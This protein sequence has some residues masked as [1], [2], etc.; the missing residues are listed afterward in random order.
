MRSGGGDQLVEFIEN[1]HEPFPSAEN[2][3]H[4]RPPAK[5]GER[6]ADENIGV[7]DRIFGLTDGGKDDISKQ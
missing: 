1:G 2:A 4:A 7:D 5:Q 6:R 3:F